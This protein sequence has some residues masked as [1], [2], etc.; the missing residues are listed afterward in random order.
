MA[1]IPWDFFFLFMD[2]LYGFNITENQ[3]VIFTI[4]WVLVVNQLGVQFYVLIEN[5]ILAFQ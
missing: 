3:M 2:N 5:A 4:W 1:K